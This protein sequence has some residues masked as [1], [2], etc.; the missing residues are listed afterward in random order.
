M[1]GQ[2]AGQRTGFARLRVAAASV[3]CCRHSRNNGGG[4]QN[5]CKH[6]HDLTPK[7]VGRLRSGQVLR[8]PEKHRPVSV[9]LMGMPATPVAACHVPET[10]GARSRLR[11][12]VKKYHGT[13]TAWHG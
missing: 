2:H 8:N 4:G 13:G 6:M 9:C 10:V 3:V 12:T 7:R 5:Q 1:E 11:Q